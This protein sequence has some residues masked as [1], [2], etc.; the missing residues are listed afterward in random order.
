M[1]VH[2]TVRTLYV[3]VHV[4]VHVLYVVV[5]HVTK[6]ICTQCFTPKGGTMALHH[7]LVLLPNLLILNIMQFN[8]TN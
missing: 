1:I 5:A 2:V 7:P 6:C 3:H 8:N 4:H